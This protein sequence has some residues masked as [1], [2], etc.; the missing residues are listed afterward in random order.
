MHTLYNDAWSVIPAE[1]HPA[2][3]GQPAAQL[4]SDIWAQIGPEMERVLGTG[5]G[6]AQYEQ[7]LPMVRGGQARETWWNYSFTALRTRTPGEAAQDHVLDFIY[8][9]VRDAAG[10]VDGTLVLVTDV[11][12]R[13]RAENALRISNWQL[14]EERA[15]LHAM[16]EAEQRTQNA[17]RR[18]N[19]TLE[20]HVKLR[21]AELERALA[22]QNRSA[23]P[24]A[25]A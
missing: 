19:E 8:Q 6:L 9:P 4:W 3:L 2:A 20:A 7:F 13:A 1:R 21:T 22:R 15:R 18:F 14:G 17:L 10:R 24:P 16:V 25:P 12:D 23:E 5:E 11:T